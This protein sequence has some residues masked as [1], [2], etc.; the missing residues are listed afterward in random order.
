MSRSKWA[1]AR[2]ATRPTSTACTARHSTA[3]P[4]VRVNR[5]LRRVRLRQKSACTS[6]QQCRKIRRER[7]FR[8]TCRERA[9]PID[10]P[11]TTRP[12]CAPTLFSRLHRTR[13][14]LLR[15]S[16]RTMVPPPLL[17]RDSTSA[18]VPTS[19]LLLSAALRL[20]SPTGLFQSNWRW[21]GKSRRIATIPVSSR[22]HLRASPLRS[23]GTP[24]APFS[25]KHAAMAQLSRWK[26]RPSRRRRQR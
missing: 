25:L 24:Y 9:R 18:N 19:R 2:R 5:Q 12:V 16:C 26:S 23:R 1:T 8:T 17:H 11:T 7:T 21:T 3:R 4:R 20:R 14:R 15:R 22:C 10:P 13:L 6:R